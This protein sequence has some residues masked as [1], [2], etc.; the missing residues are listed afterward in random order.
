MIDRELVRIFTDARL[1]ASTAGSSE[2]IHSLILPSATMLATATIG[3]AD[4]RHRAT[5]TSES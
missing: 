1:I 5:D 4:G 3:F 2:T